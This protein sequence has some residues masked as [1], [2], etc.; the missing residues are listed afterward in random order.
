VTNLLNI[1]TLILSVRNRNGALGKVRLHHALVTFDQTMQ[2][3]SELAVLSFS[4]GISI[5]MLIPFS[6]LKC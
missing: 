5:E 6:P 4:T 2:F 1:S 3:F